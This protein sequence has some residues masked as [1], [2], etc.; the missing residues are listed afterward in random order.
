MSDPVNGPGIYKT[1]GVRYHEA[2]V[3]GDLDSGDLVVLLRVVDDNGDEK[4]YSMSPDKA[5]TM[6]IYLANAAGQA[7]GG[8]GPDL[9]R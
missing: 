7:A 4:V 3:G 2:T 6:A 8:T 5:A 9:T 1:I